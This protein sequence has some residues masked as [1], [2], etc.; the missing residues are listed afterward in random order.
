MNNTAL[1]PD[2]RA[3]AGFR[4]TV[5]EAI[6]SGRRPD[7]EALTK[8]FPG[9]TAADVDALLRRIVERVELAG[10]VDG[11]PGRADEPQDP[12]DGVV[13]EAP[14]TIGG[15]EILFPI[16]RGGMAAVYLALEGHPRREVALK[17]FDPAEWED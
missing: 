17:V 3:D 10:A 15:Y 4:E 7:V 13:G 16:G 5:W 2:E 9:V 8:R 1:H 6:V 12:E 11:E 14:G